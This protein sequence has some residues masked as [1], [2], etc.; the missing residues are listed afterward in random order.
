M[1]YRSLTRYKSPID[2]ALFCLYICT[3]IFYRSVAR[4]RTINLL[5]ITNLYYMIEKSE[6]ELFKALEWL[7]AHSDNK[8]NKKLSVL[9]RN[10]AAD[11]TEF[12]AQ[13]MAY[14]DSLLEDNEKMHKKHDIKVFAK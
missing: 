14:S 3:E 5:I 13:Q 9:I 1:S 6:A 11:V 4:G 10:Y 8:F 12:I 7:E 2:K